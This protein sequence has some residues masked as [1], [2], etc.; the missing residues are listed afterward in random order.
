MSH[1]ITQCVGVD[2][3]LAC[4]VL[5]MS[6]SACRTVPSF[7][8]LLIQHLSRRPPGTFIPAEATI[9]ALVENERPVNL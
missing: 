4:N 9:V 1:L 2:S 3:S 5:N 8:A 7:F 6:D